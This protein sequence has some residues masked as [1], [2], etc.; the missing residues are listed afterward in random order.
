MSTI[1]VNTVIDSLSRT[2]ITLSS[3]GSPTI[4]NLQPTI[5][6]RDG[7]NANP[8]LVA[9]SSFNEVHVYTSTVYNPQLYLRTSLTS[10][11]LYE[12]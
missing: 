6:H 12:L 7:A 4:R 9:L 1:N 11:A 5:I 2:A 8:S 3:T 10:G